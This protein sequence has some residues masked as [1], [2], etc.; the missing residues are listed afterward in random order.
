[1]LKSGI[2]MRNRREFLKDASAAT[3]GLFF[4]GCGLS[5]YTFG[6]FQRETKRRRVMIAGRRALTVDVHCHVTI[7]EAWD[8]LKD[9]PG[10]VNVQIGQTDPA[11]PK[12]PQLDPRNVANRLAEMDAQGIDVQA[13]GINP[14]WYRTMRDVATRIIQLQN[15]RVAALCASHPDRFVGMASVALQHPDLAAQQLEQLSKS[16]QCVVR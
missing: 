7:P 14:F 9:D 15:E 16:S 5:E 3:A 4:V 6:A 10:A 11:S 13:V 8:M 12:G 1:M 2:C